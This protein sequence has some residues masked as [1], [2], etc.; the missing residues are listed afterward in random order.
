MSAGQRSPYAG[1]RFS[2]LTQHGKEREMAPLFA[3][4]LEV[5]RSKRGL[6]G[7]HASRATTSSFETSTR[8]VSPTPLD[9]PHAT[10]DR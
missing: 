1:A 6:N 4:V 3:D 8:V 5:P 2:I 10:L 7:G 9:A